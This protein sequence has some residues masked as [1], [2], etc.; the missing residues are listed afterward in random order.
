MK[1]NATSSTVALFVVGV[2]L[3]VAGLLMLRASVRA[4]LAYRKARRS[5][6]RVIGRVL[7]NRSRNT[8]EGAPVYCPVV[9]FDDPETGRRKTF[10]P[11]LSTSRLLKPGREVAVLWDQR[12]REPLLDEWPFRGGFAGGCLFFLLAV[13][14]T[15]CGAL[16]IYAVT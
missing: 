16:A 1:A 8:G 13:M 2:A 12:G 6:R 11:P 15:A 4:R 3:L 7:S 10:S 9:E 5:R 14:C